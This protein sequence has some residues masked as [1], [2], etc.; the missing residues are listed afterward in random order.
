MIS[1]KPFYKTLKQQ[2]FTEYK[3]VK[4]YDFSPNIFYRMKCGKNISTKTINTL[5]QILNCQV[6][7]IIEFDKD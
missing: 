7:D 4:E 5:C 1:Y 6:N 2:N 3:L